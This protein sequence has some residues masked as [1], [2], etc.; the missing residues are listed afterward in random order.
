MKFKAFSSLIAASTI[1]VSVLPA[2]AQFYPKSSIHRSSNSTTV[3]RSGSG[4]S[5]TTSTSKSTSSK[6]K[7]SLPGITNINR[8]SD[9]TS[10]SS[11]THR[12]HN[13]NTHSIHRGEH[14]A[15]PFSEIHQ[16]NITH[17][18]GNFKF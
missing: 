4:S 13:E 18:F 5:R 8:G 10:S 17:N 6:V 12:S 14:R 16:N 9:R 1:F 11:V 3:H 7:I 2:T 15:L